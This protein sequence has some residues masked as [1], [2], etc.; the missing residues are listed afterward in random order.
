M[1]RLLRSDRRIPIGILP[2]V[3]Q[4][5]FVALMM[6]PL[7]LQG[8][9]PSSQRLQESTASDSGPSAFAY[10]AYRSP[11]PFPHLWAFTEPSADEDRCSFTPMEASATF[12]IIP[13]IQYHRAPP[14][15]AMPHAYLGM[16][17]VV[18]VSK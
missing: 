13:T 15:S 16:Y 10:L 8:E 17:E 2:G 3:M 5:R 12:Q 11:S 4:I 1:A 14:L 7:T 6:D 18:I 9:T